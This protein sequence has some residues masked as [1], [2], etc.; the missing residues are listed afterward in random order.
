M[1]PRWKRAGAAVER[2]MGEAAGRAYVAQYFP[3]ESKAKMEAL[4]ADLRTALRGRI[5]HLQWMSPETRTKALEKLAKFNV[6]IGYPSKWRDYSALQVKE[7]D[8]L[9]D[10]ARVSQ[11]DWK[12]DLADLNKPVDKTEWG[13][14]PQTVNAYYNATR[15]EIV[16]PAAILQP[17]FFDPKAD[18]AVNYGGIGAVIGH[19]ISHG[20]DDQGAQF[21]A[22]G[23]LKNWWTPEDAEKFKA[24]TG[25]V[26]AQYNAYCPV[27][28]A[29]G[30]PAQCVKGELTLGENIAD[31]AGLT[32]AYT[33]YKLSLGGQPAPVLDG[34]TGDQRFFLGFSQVWRG[35]YRDEMAQTLL[36]IDPHSPVG[37]RATTV[38]NLDAW[39]DAF[40]PRPGEALYLTPEQRVR[41]W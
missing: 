9:G 21:D 3:P 14:T 2:A 16:F 37:L 30:K 36:V 6:K 26:V 32:V 33:A 28:A 7:G 12:R 38:R 19:E 31:L 15:N 4:V 34:F 35:K 40:K 10:V 5:E 17:P 18:D 41:I 22:T 20:F 27:P 23:T 11:F 1:R 29:D 25:Q 24:G 39:Y 8:L 13:M